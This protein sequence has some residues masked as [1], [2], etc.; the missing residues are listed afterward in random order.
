[1]SGHCHRDGSPPKP[2]LVAHRTMAI[3]QNT[4]IL[5]GILQYCFLYSGKY[6][7]DIR[8][9]GGLS[10]TWWR[11]SDLYNTNK[12]DQY[13]LRVEIQMRSVDLIESPK[14]VLGRPIYVIT[15]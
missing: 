2:G 4:R 9:V 10:Q 14:K 12:I 13:L 6:Q 3:S 15:A 8:R 1:M 7:T 5:E 11:I